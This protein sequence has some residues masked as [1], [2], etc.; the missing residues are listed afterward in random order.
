VKLKTEREHDFLDVFQWT[1]KSSIS[2]AFPRHSQGI[3]KAFPRHSQELQCKIANLDS[4]MYFSVILIARFVALQL[5][6]YAVYAYFAFYL[7]RS[8][9]VPGA[10]GQ[11]PA[12][13][14]RATSWPYVMY[15]VSGNTWDSENDLGRPPNDNIV[16]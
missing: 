5:V 14:L 3:T 16:I 2:R 15:R 9:V 13:V 8:T 1:L 7:D 4:Q 6:F 10:R 12:I 11:V